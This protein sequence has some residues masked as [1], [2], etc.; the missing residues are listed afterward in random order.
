[1]KGTS[2]QA[3]V[4]EIKPMTALLPPTFRM[5]WI[6]FNTSKGSR[7]RNTFVVHDFVGQPEQLDGLEKVR[8]WFCR[9][10]VAGQGNLL[11]LIFV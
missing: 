8:G 4:L 7:S 5:M 6:R 9:N 3:L 1:M 10:M 11:Y 2:I